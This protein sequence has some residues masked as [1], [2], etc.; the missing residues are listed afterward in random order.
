MLNKKGI[1]PVVVTALLLV[2][3]VVAVVGFQTFFNT[4]S[5]GLFSRV[6]TQSETSGVT[7]IDTIVGGELYFKN[8]FDEIEISSVKVN[9]N[10][11]F[12]SGTYTANLNSIPISNCT[13]VGKN[14]VGIVTNRGIYE[15]EIYKQNI[16][17]SNPCPS[18]YVLVPGNLDLNTSN[19]CVMKFE[20]KN[21]GGVA[22]SQGVLS[23]WVSLTQYQ[24]RANCSALGTSYHLITDNEW[25]TIAHNVEMVSGNWNSSVVGTG[26]I[27]TGHNDNNPANTLS[28]TNESDYYNG[29]GNS[30]SS[31]QIQRRV[32]ILS[33]SEMIW[34]LSGNVWEWI[35]NTIPIALRYHGGDQ[36][37]MVYDND[38]ALVNASNVPILKQPSNN[39]DADNGMGRYYDGFSLAGAYNSI[40]ESPDFCTGYCSPTA[41]FLRGGQWNDGAYAGVFTLGFHGAPSYVTTG[42]GFRCVYTQ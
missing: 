8:G 14:E 16:D 37:W 7:Q 29:T 30:N 11:C 34:D 36:G 3:A 20:A 41:A 10:D 9:G 17:Y 21:V 24:A 22:T 28:V 27:F 6:E 1:S 13:E 26:F 39:W 32:L 23:P 38:G 5:T 33:N 4:Y 42:V 25:L 2:V 40:S 12:V 18:G 31:S 19:F 35:N 15:K